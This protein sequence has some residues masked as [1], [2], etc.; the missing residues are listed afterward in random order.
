ME[1]ELLGMLLLK[2]GAAIPT[3]SSILKAEDFYLDEHKLVYSAILSLYIRKIPPSMPSLAEELRMRNELEKVGYNLIMDLGQVAFTTA[4]AESYAQKIKE[5]SLLRQLIQAGENIVNE[6]YEA[7]KPIDEILDYA[8]KQ[9]FAVTSTKNNT[10]EL[11][12]VH[13]ILQR[14]F[15]KIQRAVDNKGKPTGIGSGFTHFDKVTSGFQNSDLILIAARPS[16]GKTAFALNI[17]LNAALA[18]KTVAVFSLEMSKEQLGQRLLSIR[19]GID[20]LKMN[21]GNLSEDEIVEVAHT[22]DELASINL[23]IDDTAAISI[24]ELRSKARRLKNDRGLDLLVIDY[25]QLMQGSKGSSKGSDFNRQQEISEISRSLKALA[26][27]LKIPIIALSQLSR[28]VE[29]RADKRPL[30]SDLRESGSLEQDA[31]IVMFLYREEYYNQET[32]NVNQ[33][34]VIIAKNRNGPTSSI[35]LQFTKE[36]MRFATLAYEDNE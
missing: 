29:L 2:D 6:S 32:E 22:V 15:E 34:E 16:M 11:E 26:R 3:V 19:S 7:K 23:F 5:K 24:L 21:T 8:E 33:A 13:P 18:R 9:V 35:K 1:L 30:L 17:A 28:N 20:S 27:E 12:I 25:L 14:A 4:Y 36:C 10:A 31:D